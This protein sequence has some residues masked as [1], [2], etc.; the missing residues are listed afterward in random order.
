MSKKKA[1]I[2]RLNALEEI[3]RKARVSQ[4]VRLQRTINRLSRQ[5]QESSSIIT[6]PAASS[7]SL[8]PRGTTRKYYAVRRGRI[9]NVIYT[10]WALC[11]SQVLHFPGAEFRAFTTYEAAQDYLDSARSPTEGRR[12]ANNRAVDST[13]QAPPTTADSTT[14]TASYWNI[15]LYLEGV[16]LG[17]LI[18]ALI[19][20]WTL[21]HQ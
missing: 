15:R 6:A 13:Y 4:E 16:A 5:E 8:D 1:T 9:N 21:L 18:G 17:I 11:K 19:T 7:Q 10:S 2:N 12:V 3:K 20:L 14:Q